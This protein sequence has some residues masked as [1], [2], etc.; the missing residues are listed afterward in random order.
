MDGKMGLGFNSLSAGNPTFIDMLKESGE[1]ENRIFGFYVNTVPFNSFGYGFPASNLQIGGYDLQT[2][3]TSP[4]FTAV[5]YVSEAA[6]WTVSFTSCAIN[7]DMTLETSFSG[8]FDSGTALTVVPNAAFAMIFSYVVNLQSRNC[9]I[10]SELNM[11]V[12]EDNNRDYLPGL[13]LVTSTGSIT[14]AAKNL[15]ECKSG[16]CLMLVEEGNEW[17]FGDSFLRTYYTVYDMDHL[18]ISFASAVT[19]KS[20]SKIMGIIGLLVWAIQFS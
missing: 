9:V 4:I 17:I 13:T 12:C 11:I 19:S 10:D 15:W 2:Y 8:K 16:K 18:T 3:S 6:W 7:G 14:G 5:F 1:I 20:R